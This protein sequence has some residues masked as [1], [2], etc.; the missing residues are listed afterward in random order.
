MWE[1]V[2]PQ[3]LKTHTDVMKKKLDYISQNGI[4]QL[5]CKII[6]LQFF[7]PASLLYAANFKTT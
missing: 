5:Q 2:L 6:L 7:L 3:I 4:Y 1:L